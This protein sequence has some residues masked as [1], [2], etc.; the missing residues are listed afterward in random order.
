MRGDRL[1]IKPHHRHAAAALAEHLLP[2]ISAQAQPLVISIGGESG[3]GKSEL[4]E[5]LS[6]VLTEQGI[7]TLV[8]QQD[9]YFVLPPKTNDRRRRE[10]IDWVGPQEVRLDLLDEHLLQLARGE[11]SIV[12]PL[13]YYDEDR[14][15]EET[16]SAEGVRVILVEGTYVSQL[17][18]VSLRVF[19]DRSFAVT[20]DAR[21]ERA[22]EEQD[23]F[24][25]RVLQIEHATIS[26]HK[27]HADFLVDSDYSVVE[28]VPRP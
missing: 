25:E 1:I 2:Q 5:A 3:S 21:A 6:Q 8:L 9:D 12:K 24:L 26:D 4:A 28:P 10:D 18:N 17:K 14:I 16:V 27:K 11:T 20:R 15:G 13:V 7:S 19:I 23:A 22:R